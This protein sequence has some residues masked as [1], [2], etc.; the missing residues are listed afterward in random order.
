MAMLESNVQKRY[1]QSKPGSAALAIMPMPGAKGWEDGC[2]V[3]V[4][5]VTPFCLSAS[6]KQSR[7]DG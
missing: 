6:Q 3:D 7:V 1:S 4:V 5:P 2:K